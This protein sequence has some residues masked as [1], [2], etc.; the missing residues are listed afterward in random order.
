L[1]T[2]PFIIP[3]LN[4]DDKVEKVPTPSAGWRTDKSD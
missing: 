1:T 2:S 3:F 4:R